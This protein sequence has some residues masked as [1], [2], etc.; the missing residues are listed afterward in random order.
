MTVLEPLDDD[1]VKAVEALR[2]ARDAIR[3]W[4]A[5]E[6]DAKSILLH[7]LGTADQGTIAGVPVVERVIV[8]SRRLDGTALKRDLPDLWSQYAK[9][10]TYP[11]LILSGDTT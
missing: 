11:R 5:I 3:E 9:E 2:Q 1:A 8:R 7:K 10:S 6:D 4:S